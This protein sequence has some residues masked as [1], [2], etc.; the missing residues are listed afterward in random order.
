MDYFG[1]DFLNAPDDAAHFGEQ[2][3]PAADGAEGHLF[4]TVATPVR[5]SCVLKPGF[6]LNLI[7]LL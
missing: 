1:Q 7:L 4:Q 2:L 3:N 5:S 6:S